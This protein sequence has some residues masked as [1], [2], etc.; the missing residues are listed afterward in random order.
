MARVERREHGAELRA[1]DEQRQH[2]ERRIG[3]G[4]DAVAVPD[5]E[6]RERV[7]EPIGRGVEL[8]VGER[9][10]AQRRRHLVRHHFRIAPH[11]VADQHVHAR[12][13][14]P[15]ARRKGSALG[16]QTLMDEREVRILSH[17]PLPLLARVTQRFPKAALIAVPN[18][19]EL[20]ADAARRGAAHD[21]LGQPEPR[22]RARARRALGARVRHRRQR[23]SVPRA[24]RR[25]RSRARAA[26]A[27]SRSR[28]G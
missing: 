1:R 26:P 8:R 4:E 14:C 5:A 28:S 6:A 24:R 3:P 23:V 2:V 11:D 18:E 17:V 19:G 7:R 22:A 27:R 21:G 9:A 16:R 10:L 12:A 13:A 25:F 20:P 15:C